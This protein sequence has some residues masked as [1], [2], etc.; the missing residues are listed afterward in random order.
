MVLGV[1]VWFLDTREPVKIVVCA[2]ALALIAA[3]FYAYRQLT[4]LV[5]DDVKRRRAT[6]GQ[7]HG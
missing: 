6:K 5:R 4:W 1:G 7:K 3:S 2:T